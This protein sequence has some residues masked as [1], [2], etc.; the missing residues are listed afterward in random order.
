M[1]TNPIYDGCERGGRGSKGEEESVEQ[2][3]RG[4]N[5]Q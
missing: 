1:E 5:H 2:E 4:T 3:E